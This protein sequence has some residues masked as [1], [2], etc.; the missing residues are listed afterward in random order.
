MYSQG[1]LCLVA[2]CFSY[3][4]VAEIKI[5]VILF[6]GIVSFSYKSKQ[7]NTDFFLR[8]DHYFHV[9]STD[10]MN[11]TMHFKYMYFIE[12][13]NKT[14]KMKLQDLTQSLFQF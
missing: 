3:L 14:S 7:I 11:Y 4:L 9:I 13:Y 10:Y 2:I 8:V 5:A 1:V 12:M 6:L